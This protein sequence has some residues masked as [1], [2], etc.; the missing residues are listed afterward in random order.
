MSINSLCIYFSYIPEVHASE[1]S[2]KKISD[3]KRVTLIIW[4]CLLADDLR[5]RTSTGFPHTI[6]G[7]VVFEDKDGKQC[8]VDYDGIAELSCKFF[9]KQFR[10][11]PSKFKETTW[12][13]GNQRYGYLI[14]FKIVYEE[15]PTLFRQPYET[16]KL[17]LGN[18]EAECELA[19]N[20]YS[21]G[22]SDWKLYKGK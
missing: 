18:L 8:A 10:I 11:D 17:K 7:I 20:R 5:H 19:P 4:S 14:E 22:Q 15:A 3:I 13:D 16:V 6:R 2:V 9:K 1:K 12:F 21:S